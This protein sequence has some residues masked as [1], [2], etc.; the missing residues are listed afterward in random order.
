[1]NRSLPL[2]SLLLLFF[3]AGAHAQMY[4]WVG[5]DGKTV[6]SDTPPPASVKQVERKSVSTGG[7]IDADLPFELVEPVKTNPVTLYTGK[8]CEP[9]NDGRKLLNARGIPFVEKTVVSNEDITKL[10]E[11]GGE[12]QLP[13]LIVG[14]NKKQGFETAAWDLVLNAAG[15][16]ETNKLPKNYRNPAAEPAAPAPKAATGGT[17]NGNT[18]AEATAPAASA[19]PAPTGKVPPGFRF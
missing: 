19:L 9:C 4:K 5:P 12:A 11:V 1:M 7:G 14:R 8:N 3:M 18:P 2:C 17:T 15:Y 16:P 10:K 13:L 6:Y